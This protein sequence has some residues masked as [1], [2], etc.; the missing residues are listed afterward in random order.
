[1]VTAS[2]AARA[3]PSGTIALLFTDVESSVARWEKYPDEMHRVIERHDALLRGAIEAAGGYVFKTVGD[4]VCAAFPTADAAVRSAVEA[5]RILSDEDWSAVGG[6]RVRM[7]VHSGAAEL[8]DGDY[9]GQSVN[10]VARLLSLAH[11]GQ[12]LVSGIAKELCEGTLPSGLSLRDLGPHR[13]RDLAHPE[14]VYQVIAPGLP[15]AFPPPRSLAFLPNN[16]PLQLTPFFGRDSEIEEI[17]SALEHARL[18][19][20]VGAGGVGKT[21]LS[22]QAGA[23]LLEAFHDGIWF[24]DLAV[25]RDETAVARAIAQVLG[26]HVDL[27][28]E[29]LAAIVSALRSK[30]LLIVLDNCEHVIAAASAAADALLRGCPSIR[31]LAT[32]REGLS[33]AGERVIRVPSLQLPP[34]GMAL[35]G[36]VAARYGAVALFVDR[37]QAASQSF[38]LTDAN[39]E[40]VVEICRRLDGI[41]L[42]IELAAARLRLLSLEQLASRL[43]ERFRLLTGGNRTAL[44]RQQTMRA[45]IDW[46]YDLLSDAE[47]TLFRRSAVFAGSFSLDAVEAVCSNSGVDSWDAFDVLASL[48]EKS[49]I[50][51]ELAGSEQRYR[52]LESARQY[53]LERLAESGEEPG[54]REQHAAYFREFTLDTERR[55]FTAPL[56]AWL[57]SIDRDAENVHAALRWT[58]EQADWQGAAVIAGA[59]VWYWTHG[60]QL[61]TPIR[62]VQ[63]IVENEASIAP[64]A[65]AR[66]WYA[67]SYLLGKAGEEK[68]SRA[69]ADTSLALAEACADPASIAHALLCQASAAFMDFE[70]DAEAAFTK[71]TEIFAQVGNQRMI[72]VT[73]GRRARSLGA[74]YRLDEAMPLYERALA[75]SRMAGDD[76]TCAQVLSNLAEAAF[77]TGKAEL[78]L[79]YA[80]EALEFAT[81]ARYEPLIRVTY[82][83]MVVYLLHENMVDD[84]VDRARMALH[85]ARES[86]T[87]TA[88]SL[89]ALHFAGIAAAR[90]ACDNAAMLLGYFLR[91]FRDLYGPGRD[92]ERTERNFYARILERIQ[93][94]IDDD[95]LQSLL[96]AGA[97]LTIDEALERMLAIA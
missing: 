59:F 33:I 62:T 27:T 8:R 86:G 35:S 13:L 14:Q 52:L 85:L 1:M 23:D 78:A 80:G 56:K 75:M 49:M 31:I 12:I 48:V 60:K 91:A 36:A 45:L 72:G 26:V 74:R 96:D 93:R 71:V 6:L 63:T 53:A 22:L 54:I 84:A 18:V 37:A 50:T 70:Y 4:A 55:Y 89:V 51:G 3:L 69:A 41:A 32:S 81:T 40:M 92:M 7:A 95:R 88:V 44:P 90:D 64:V 57:A 38:T 39:V 28:L 15:A 5:Q 66:C 67:L 87:S 61:V 29:P 68:A 65:L 97:A 17:V 58:M 42:A 83:N 47:R 16:L 46:S 10:R 73:L 19:T 24:V 21:R 2:A 25:L 20:L 9:F 11:G 94:D 77:N 43:K 30:H 34:H 79:R 82:A 76:R